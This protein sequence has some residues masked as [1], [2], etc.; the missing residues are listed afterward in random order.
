MWGF[1]KRKRR[2]SLEDQLA[3]LAECGIRLRPGISVE[4]LLVS[5]EREKYSV[6]KWACRS[7]G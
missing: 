5:F 4:Q 3:N 7:C 6:R 2:M 1:F